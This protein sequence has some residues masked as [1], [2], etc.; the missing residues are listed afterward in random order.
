MSDG[1]SALLTVYWLKEK[2]SNWGFS[3]RLDIIAT[4]KLI[5]S[6]TNQVKFFWHFVENF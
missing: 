1:V 4:D 5:S 2:P 6:I 3:Y